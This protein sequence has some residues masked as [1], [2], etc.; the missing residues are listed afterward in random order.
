MQRDIDVEL[1][2]VDLKGVFQ[3][4]IYINRKDYALDLLE[5]GLAISMGGKYINKKYEEAE[6]YARKNKFGL[7]S[8]N[9]NLSS[10]KGDIEKQFNDIK[11]E[12]NGTII[13]VNSRQ[14]FYVEPNNCKRV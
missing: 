1:K 8:Q 2:K 7:W 3:A 10:L 6:S 9:L 14:E 12:K 11:L 4:T 5:K 13:E